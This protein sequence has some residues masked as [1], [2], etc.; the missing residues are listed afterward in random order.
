MGIQRIPPVFPPMRL[1]VQYTRCT[2]GAPKPKPYHTAVGV[3]RQQ[4]PP[5]KVRV[6]RRST[7][8]VSCAV[9][10]AGPLPHVAATL[11]HGARSPSPPA[12]IHG[13]V[14]QWSVRFAKPFYSAS[15]TPRNKS[16]RPRPSRP[17][18]NDGRRA[19][20]ACRVHGASRSGE[21]TRRNGTFKGALWCPDVGRFSARR[22]RRASVRSPRVGGSRYARPFVI[23]RAAEPAV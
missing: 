22:R 3:G 10:F 16:H 8:P 6:N 15:R 13:T 11:A 9:R 4:E 20:T 18:G 23:S 1:R 12:V 21:G 14:W 19:R 7:V 2:Y 5:L 17:A